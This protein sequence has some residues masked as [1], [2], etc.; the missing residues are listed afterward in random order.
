MS[1]I[2]FLKS[3]NFAMHCS[4]KCTNIH[5]S[6]KANDK[7]IQT[8]ATKTK[9][10]TDLATERRKSTCKDLYGVEFISQTD[11]VRKINSHPSV[12]L[13]AARSKNL[14]D[15]NLNNKKF[16][17]NRQNSCKEFW[18][19]DR[20]DELRKIKSDRAVIQHKET[21]LDDQVKKYF[22]E[23]YQGSDNQKE[24]SKR[25][26]LNNP[27]SKPEAREKSRQTY[28]KNNELGLHNKETK[29]KKKLYKDTILMYQSS[30]ELDFLE[31]CDTSNMLH[32]I[33]NA[34]CLSADYY[35][36]NFYAPDYI[37]DDIYIIE[38]KSWYIENLQEKR[39]PGILKLKEQLVAD[40]GYK[41]LYIKDKDYSNL[42]SYV[43]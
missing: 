38:I 32:R 13:C 4:V 25:L 34:P 42:L 14:T 27:G 10:E 33:K 22:K 1:S 31:L 11:E 41:F 26:K 30:Y 18:K 17:E 39:C 7:R 29:F 37:L 9:E 28:I 19:S 5:N 6:L 16:Q 36:Y 2:R 15:L 3:G 20:S 12:E 8:W 43:D 40:K 24:K 21:N 23:R 35:P